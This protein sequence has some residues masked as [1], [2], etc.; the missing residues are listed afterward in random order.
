MAV[1]LTVPAKH[2]IKAY[3]RTQVEEDVFTISDTNPALQAAES[4]VPIR[5]QSTRVQFPEQTTADTVAPA[6]EE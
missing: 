5:S 1:V 4:G 3:Q 2:L 6:G